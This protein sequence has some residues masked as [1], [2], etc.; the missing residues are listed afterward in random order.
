MGNCNF[1]SEK[2]NDSTPGKQE[3]RE[4]WKNP[5]TNE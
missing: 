4:G 5:W 1:S 2:E 3:G